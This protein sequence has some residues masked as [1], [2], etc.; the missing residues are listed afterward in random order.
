MA[1]AA[2]ARPPLFVADAMLLKLARWLRILGARV[3]AAGD[4][5]DD[6]AVIRLAMRKGGIL[7]TR[8]RPMAAKARDYVPVVLFE[9]TDLVKQ[10]AELSRAYSIPLD[11]L[12]G[13]TICPHCGGRL[14][15][16]GRDAVK[17]RVW[18]RVLKEHEKFWECGR[19]PCGKIYW[20][21]SHWRKINA[22][23]AKV[24]RRVGKRA[25][26]SGRAP[27]SAPA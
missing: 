19:K 14:R 11:G 3:V 5:M 16:V 4:R 20:E 15:V 21:G 7:L 24:R 13:R 23:V 10:L 25:G 26:T 1:T 6:D 27:R 18:P 9:T 12:A 8:D 17:G 2:K 22:T